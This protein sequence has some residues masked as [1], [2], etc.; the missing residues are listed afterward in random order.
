MVG[1]YS[2]ELYRLV[3]RFKNTWEYQTFT[4]QC[5]MINNLSRDDWRKLHEFSQKET[6][7]KNIPNVSVTVHVLENNGFGESYTIGYREYREDLIIISLW[8]FLSGKLIESTH[9]VGLSWTRKDAYFLTSYE[10]V[11]MVSIHLRLQCSFFC[12]SQLP[13]WRN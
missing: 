13:I 6:K 1:D 7:C 2:D 8:I 12:C 3:R 9:D 11:V 4:P 5:N 10:L